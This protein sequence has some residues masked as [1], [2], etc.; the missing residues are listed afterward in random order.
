MRRRAGVVALLVSLIGMFLV[1]LPTSSAL[2]HGAMTS[3][4]T[5]TYFCY[6]ENP[7]SPDSAACKDAVAQGGTQ[8]LYDWFGLL[9]SNAAG[10]HRE[11][12]P[13]GQLCG[14]G[15][16]KYAAYNMAR[17][18][19]PSTT[20]RSG[21]QFDFKYNAW[22]PH[23]GTWEM[24]VTKNGFDPRQPLK[25][26]DL[27]ATPFYSITNPPLGG[28]EYSWSAQLP[29]GKTGKHIIYTI[30][31]RSDSPEAFYN[32]SD[33]NFTNGGGG[34][35]QAPTA[36]GT[37]TASE[38]T[39][40]GAKLSWAAAT[41][42]V[43]VSA[44]RVYREAGA[45]DQL[46]STVTGTSATLTGLTAQTAYS[47]YVVALDAAGNTS[48]ASPAVSL[49]TGSGPVTGNCAVAYKVGTQWFGGFTG[50]VT[51]TNTGTT[52]VSGWTLAFDWNDGQQLSQGWS[53]TWAQT[54]RRVTAKNVDFNGTLPPGG[55]TTIGF[56]ASMA[57]TNSAPTA[58]TLNDTACAVT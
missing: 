43:G 37:P 22:A 36:P 14:A 7:E 3:P 30:W 18:D 35:T 6:Q 41:D 10:R 58:F 38:V 25:W 28:G 21:S 11:I 2:A 53:A 44:Y 50:S 23:P 1:I 5:R 49:T 16:T 24:Y 55:S 48:A 26:S 13:D 54:A 20:L 27:E 52:A 57:T 15:T 17:D 9:I 40:T 47:F 45:Q 33:V 42:N 32:C 56:N 12:I 19:W 29:S 34:D 46:V 4:A 51:I 39:A 31:Q 8:P